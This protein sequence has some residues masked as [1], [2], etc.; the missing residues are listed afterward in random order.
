MIDFI[1]QLIPLTEIEISELESVIEYKTIKKD[2]LLIRE[3]QICDFIAFVQ[4]GALHCYFLKENGNEMTEDFSTENEFITDYFS[5]LTQLPS[6][7]N[8]VA[9]EDSELLILWKKDIENFYKKHSKFQELGRLIAE[10]LY[11]EK[12]QRIR[13][14]LIEDAEQ[15]YLSLCQNRPYLVDRI[16]HYHLAS[17][18]GISPE[19]LSRIRKKVHKNTKFPI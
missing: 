15:K 17:Y 14:F 2:E 5:F 19:T 13:S 1:Q 18:L 12:Y 8:T 10:S 16:Q 3:G 4:K 9:L 6:S 7:Q 11:I